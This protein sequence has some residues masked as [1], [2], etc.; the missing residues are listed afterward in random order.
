M[1]TPKKLDVR[2]AM[3]TLK[4]LQAALIKKHGAGSAMLLDEN[5]APPIAPPSASVGVTNT[6]PAGATAR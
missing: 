6:S 3:P 1:A 2:A 5:K 4:E